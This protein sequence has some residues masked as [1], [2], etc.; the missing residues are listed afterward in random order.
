MENSKRD[1]IIL[2]GPPTCGKGTQAKLISQEF[3]NYI[4]ISTGDLLRKSGDKSGK[5][6]PGEDI[7]YRV[8]KKISKYEQNKKF[9]LDGIPR[10][11]KQIKMTFDRF[12]V[13]KII[14][15]QL[16]NKDI[17]ARSKIRNRPGRNITDRIYDFN[18]LTKPAIEMLRIENNDL[19]VE[20]KG[21]QDINDIYT[22]ISKYFKN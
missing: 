4:H 18:T 1:A 11:S 19:F 17:I 12:N 8:D 7:M 22:S 15:L 20:I 14:Y 5:F 10:T 13:E 2:M 16:D 9:I 21:N 3:P 6:V